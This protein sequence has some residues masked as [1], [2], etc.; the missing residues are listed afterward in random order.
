MLNQKRTDRE[1]F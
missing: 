1:R